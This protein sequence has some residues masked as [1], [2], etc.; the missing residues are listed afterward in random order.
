MKYSLYI[1]VLVVLPVLSCF[2]CKN[3]P[4]SSD[5][6]LADAEMNTE[7]EDTDPV[8][9]LPPVGNTLPVSVFRETWA[10]VVAGREAA[11][12]PGLPLSDIG[13]FGAEIDSYGSLTEVPKRAKLPA[14]SGT[15]GSPR[16]H[17]VVKCDSR[18][19][20]HFVLVPGSAER[21]ALIADLIAA[22]KNFDGLQ[23]DFENVPQRDGAAFHSFLAELR[24]ARGNKM[25]TIALP[26]R[27]RK[28]NNDVYDYEK[29]LPL[30]D[31]ILV[32][33][34]D[35]H[36][37]TSAPGPIASLSWCKK[38]ATYSLSVVGREKLIMGIP[39][40]GRAWGNINPSQAHVYTGIERVINENSVKEIR[41]E[42]GIPTFDY[43][44]PVS[45]K[46]YYDDEYSLSARM[47]MYHAMDITAIGFWRLGQET[48]AV[49]KLIKLEAGSGK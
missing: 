47:E 42:N 28:L 9:D 16:V 46:V 5:I 3:V 15:A 26:A 40:Y 41:R 25:F 44:I 29:I 24:A 13:Y 48:P 11:L 30:V 12:I 14:V 32:M 31:R 19:L 21:K 43:K 45:V 8:I 35:E 18:S 36:W 1:L 17:L 4:P 10:Y 27:M 23:I 38:V 39:F 2:G 7:E 37:S 33:A 34:Y 20:T 49:W 6:P 22:T